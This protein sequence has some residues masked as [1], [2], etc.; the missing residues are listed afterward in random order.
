M[1]CTRCDAELET[2]TLGGLC[3]VCLLDAALPDQTLQ[4]AGEFRYDLI[5]EIAR[6]GMGV[7]YRA[8]QHGS[9]R[10]VAVK[11][12]LAEHAATPGIME[13]FHAEAE[14]VASLDHPHILPIYE[15]GEND[16]RPFYSMKFVEGGTLRERIANFSGNPRA[17]AHLISLVARAVH[18]AHQRGILH[19]D[20]KPGNIL[21]EGEEGLPYVADFGLAKWLGRENRLTIASTALGTPNYMAPE[22][23]LGSSASLTTAADIYSLG[24]ILY[25][26]LA[27]R[28]P[29]LAD[30]PLETLR[31][32]GQTVAPPVRSFAPNVPRD[33]EVICLK[34]LAKE[35]GARYSSAAALADDLER[36]REG[37]TIM[38]RPASSPERLWRWAKRN[39]ALATV[40]AALLVAVLAVAVGSSI[41]ATR[42]RISNDRARAAELQAREE[43]R[44][45][46][47][48]QARA[49]RL[50]G[51]MGQRFDAL[52]ALK[53]AAS[54]RAGADLRT[55]AFAALAL[56]DMSVERTWADRAS[57]NSPAAFD[58]TL[59]RYVVESAPGVLTVRRSA[60]QSEV[61]QLP[62]PDGNPR[63][64]YIAPFSVD[65]TKIAARF[66]NDLV[67]VYESG[68]GRLLFELTGRPVITN[69]RLYAYDF[70]F[71]PDG[72]ALAVSLPEGGFSLHD[73]T[74]GL[75]TGRMSMPFAPA[76]ISFS[77]DGERVAVAAQKSATIEVYD[78]RSGRQEQ[79]LSH[80]GTVFYIAWHPRAAMQLA[81]GCIDDKVYV[82]DV[83]AAR[84]LHVLRGHEGDP[85]LLAFRPDGKIL[86][87]AARD[88]S[89]RLWSLETGACLVN[90]YGLY[91]EPALRFSAD[92]Q[93]LATG[94]EGT[95][96][97]ISRLALDAPRRTIYRCA[98]SD[99]FSRVNG[100]SCSADGRLLSITLRSDGVHLLSAETGAVL[101]DLPLWPGEMKTAML[102]PRSDALICSGQQS[103]LWKY[104]LQYNADG[105]L[106]I[107]EPEAV[108][109]R[110]GFLLTDI[111]GDPPVAA[112]YGA[113]LEKF[114]LV[115][116]AAP[117]KVIDLP[118][119]SQPS[120]IFLSPDARLAATCDWEGETAGESDVRIWN[121][122]TGALI[123]RLG[124]GPNNSVRFSP[125][126][127]LLVA[128]GTKAGAGVWHLPEFTRD[129]HVK[130]TGDDGWF[131]PDEKILAVVEADRLD[132]IRIANGELLGSF[133]ADPTMPFTFS[134]DGRKMWMG[135][136]TEFFEWDLTAVRAELETLGL[137]WKD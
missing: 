3:P 77:P 64:L 57:S 85:P 32:V 125:S 123:R 66:A 34:C 8:I 71:T 43:L 95:S 54:V 44:S 100:I 104:P 6:G 102:T 82:W 121:A 137:N 97:T 38:A 21:L 61:A 101:A 115:P 98:A 90:G 17:T 7:V 83:A 37:R 42:L 128:S 40:S 130:E 75:E 131:S 72:A 73:A 67:R 20:L 114:S 76:I 13:R 87:S 12:I 93:R 25:E 23:A 107:A 122:G 113:K 69:G 56:P 136:P 117:D 39:R 14:A 59:G 99:W 111:Q 27:G 88:L 91:G 78:R 51:R 19:R 47:V 133:P 109:R 89:V 112:L 110:A 52:S 60:D 29:F 116:L 81:S 68:S 70:G 9:Q 28:P 36:W 2:E 10:Q 135:Y 120:S 94:S 63:V 126:A 30:T 62:A 127:R 124:T 118:V 103:G 4:D 86:A 15:I 106:K 1:R 50:T 26:L 96:L 33:L 65:D 5:E 31:L 41:A 80:P 22:Q 134:P 55:E 35:P 46:S 48:A 79:T 92:G 11:M 45:A 84:Q 58:S 132:F 129:D 74:S 24:A 18:H 16:G 105:K 108:D 53:K 49:T 119:G